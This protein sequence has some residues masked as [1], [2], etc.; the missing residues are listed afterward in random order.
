MSN[1]TASSGTRWARLTLL[2]QAELVRMA[3]RIP[4]EFCAAEQRVSPKS[5]RS[6]RTRIQWKLRQFWKMQY[7]VHVAQ[8]L[9]APSVTFLGLAF[10]AAHARGEARPNWMAVLGSRSAELDEA[11]RAVGEGSPH[12]PT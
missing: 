6:R 12:G 4:A 3:L 2:E 8:L 7:P 5:I 1:L 11:V 10:A 9:V